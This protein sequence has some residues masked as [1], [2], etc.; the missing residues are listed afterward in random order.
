[1]NLSELFRRKKETDLP[2]GYPHEFCPRCEANLTLQKGYDNQLPYWICRGCGEMLINPAV[3][4]VPVNEE[5]ERLKTGLGDGGEKEIVWICDQC[6]AMLN[7]QPG[8]RE[9]CGEWKCTECG[10][11]NR[12]DA[13]EVFASD[14]EYR[15]ELQNPY[16]GLSDEAVLALSCYGEV[17]RLADR[18]NIFLVRNRETGETVVKKLLRAYDAGVYSYLQAHPV[19]H[20]PRILELYEGE[21][22]LIVMEEYIRGSTVA[23]M[24]EAGSFPEQR[25]VSIIKDVCRILDELH[26]LPEPIVHRDVKPG[27]L[28]I[29]P[30]GETVLLDMNAAKWINPAKSEDTRYMGTQY[31]AAPEQVGYGFSASTDRTDIYAVG[32]LLNVMLT[33]KFPKEQKAS[34]KVWDII[35]RCIRLDADQRYTAKELIKALEAL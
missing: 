10:F 2:E 8:F 15:R 1:M 19:K 20:M 33:G 35:E 16:R 29:T 31:Y 18:E 22:C 5:L 11:V 14:D 30:E 9:D 12:I 4:T 24:L 17:G 21:N 34:G 32:M 27:N 26:S 7:V 25:A 28:M 3:G 23:E 6:E 13:S